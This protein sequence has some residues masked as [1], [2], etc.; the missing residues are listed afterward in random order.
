M[1]LCGLLNVPLSWQIIVVFTYP[2]RPLWSSF[3]T[4][5][6]KLDIN[7]SRDALSA[8]LSV[9][10]RGKQTEIVNKFLKSF[11]RALAEKDWLMPFES[12]QYLIIIF[13]VSTVCILNTLLI[14]IAKLL[15][16]RQIFKNEQI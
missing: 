5:I 11:K 2:D 3:P 12:F 15:I 14:L 4:S 16:S 9:V 8:S 10:C 1:K 6:G 13:R 7:T